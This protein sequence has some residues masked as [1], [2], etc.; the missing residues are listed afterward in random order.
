MP[1]TW[2]IRSQRRRHRRVGPDDAVSDPLTGPEPQRLYETPDGD[3]WQPAFAIAS[4]DRPERTVHVRIGP[5]IQEVLRGAHAPLRTVRSYIPWIDLSA[6]LGG[7]YGSHVVH[8][9]RHSPTCPAMAHLTA[10]RVCVN[11]YASS[12]LG[13]HEIRTGQACHWCFLQQP[14]LVSFKDAMRIVSV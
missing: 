9:L 12:I 13:L 11:F 10:S 1:S 5:Q 2:Q 8:Y 7:C 3:C 14:P 4:Q 6:S